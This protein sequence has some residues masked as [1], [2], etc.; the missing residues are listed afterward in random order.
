MNYGKDRGFGVEQAVNQLVKRPPETKRTHTSNLPPLGELV[1]TNMPSVAGIEPK[2]IKLDDHLWNAFD[3]N[4]TEISARYI[5]LL[6]VKRG[7]WGPFTDAD[8]AE[9]YPKKFGKITY[10][11]LN[12]VQSYYHLPTGITYYIGSGWLYEV[13]GKYYVTTDFVKRCY[14]NAFR[15]KDKKAAEKMLE[16]LR[17][18]WK[19]TEYPTDADRATQLAQL[20]ELIGATAKNEDSNASDE[21]GQKGG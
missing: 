3:H 1:L 19:S 12:D 7:H 8:I 2:D 6:A 5:C 10:N 16:S 15:N 9:V 17:E 14:F 11:R 4:E 21:G 20:Q 13:D 18:N